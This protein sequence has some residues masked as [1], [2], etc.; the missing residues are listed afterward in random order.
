MLW[1]NT[2]KVGCGLT[3]YKD[4][5][6]F[7]KLYTCDYAPAGNF[8]N[9]QMYKIGKACS[10]CPK[11]MRCRTSA[12]GC[13]H[14]NVS[15]CRQA[16]NGRHSLL[17]VLETINEHRGPVLKS[18][19]FGQIISSHFNNTRC[20]CG[21]SI[22]ENIPIKPLIPQEVSSPWWTM[23]LENYWKA[24]QRP[25][26]SPLYRMSAGERWVSATRILSKPN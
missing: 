15:R 8:I 25:E 22:H 7:A 5:K 26:V 21:F 14:W 3:E 2:N 24:R 9:G 12:N 13:L 18:I 17:P 10:S 11:N 4:G 1:S 23:L 20:D 19:K 6:W 16:V